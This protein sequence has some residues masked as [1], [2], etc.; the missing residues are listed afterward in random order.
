MYLVLIWVY[1]QYVWINHLFTWACMIDSIFL[2]YKSSGLVIVSKNSFLRGVRWIC[3]GLWCPDLVRTSDEASL[4]LWLFF[5]T[6]RTCFG[7]CLIE[8]NNTRMYWTLC[9][10]GVRFTRH[11]VQCLRIW[12]WMRL[13]LHVRVVP[14]GGLWRARTMRLRIDSLPEADPPWAVKWQRCKNFKK[15]HHC[16]SSWFLAP[17]RPI[18]FSEIW[19]AP[20]WLR[21]RVQGGIFERFWVECN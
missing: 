18:L 8:Y 16:Q 14:T 15:K 17:M 9:P 13:E 11:F 12:I 3:P 2:G 7:L 6:Q 4:A 1:Q 19:K 10:V 5:H 21:N 20:L